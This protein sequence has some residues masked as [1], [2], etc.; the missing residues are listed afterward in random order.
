MVDERVSVRVER[1]ARQKRASAR[2]RS[3]IRQGHVFN[4]TLLLP[5]LA[6]F[7]LWVYMPAIYGIYLSFTNASLVAPAKFVGLQNYARLSSDPLF[8]GSLIRTFVYAALVVLPTLCIGLALARLTMRITRARGLFMTLFFLPFVVPGIVAALVFS[9]LFNQYGL[10]N[11]LLGI[12]ISWLQDP[13]AAMVALSATATW[14]MTGYY[15]VIFMAGYQQLPGELVEAAK[16]D[17]ANSWKQFRFVELPSLRPTMLFAVVSATAA[18][19]TDFGTPFILNRGGPDFGTT[20]L[21][22][23]IYNQTFQYSNAGYGE[24]ISVVLLVIALVLTVIQVGWMLRR[25]GDS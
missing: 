17:G 19:M 18:V 1:S 9:L 7:I 4:I 13:S 14:S 22:L 6:F 15:V 16:L 21:P 2:N 3:T 10:I 24:A 25:N 11:E 23:Y 20:T 5:A 8:Q 12:H